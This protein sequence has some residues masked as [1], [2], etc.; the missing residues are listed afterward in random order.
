MN[1]NIRNEI[2]KRRKEGWKIVELEAHYGVMYAEII[3]I[4]GEQEK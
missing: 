1:K 4:L 2:R 3:E